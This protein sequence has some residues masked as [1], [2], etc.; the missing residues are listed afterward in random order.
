MYWNIIK[1]M[2]AKIKNPYFSGEDTKRE[3]EKKTKLQLT[4]TISG[5]MTIKLLCNL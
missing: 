3:E 5:T 4:M 2:A 1:R